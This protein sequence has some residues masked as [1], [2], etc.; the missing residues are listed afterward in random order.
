MIK[1]VFVQCTSNYEMLYKKVHDHIANC[2][3]VHI[4][5]EFKW[6]RLQGLCDFPGKIE[7]LIVLQS[8]LIHTQ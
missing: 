4:H 5:V 6:H 7:E 8:V 1:H 2:T 3:L